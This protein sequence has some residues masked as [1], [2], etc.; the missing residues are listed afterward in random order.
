MAKHSLQSDLDN[1]N[2]SLIGLKSNK[3]FQ[4]V[5]YAINSILNIQLSFSSNTTYNLKGGKL[6]NFELFDFY[7]DDFLIEYIVIPNV[8]AL[9]EKKIEFT[10]K[11]NL[12]SE[13]EVDESFKLIKELPYID[14][15]II[16]KGET[17][18]HQQFIIFDLINKSNYFTL[19]QRIEPDL[20]SSRKNLIF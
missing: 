12:F 13:I 4:E 11:Q 6:F 1:E 7:D 15:F 20:L 5:I 2:F 19:A 14:Y 18:L 8:G 16:M 10:E 3:T 9:F 17:I